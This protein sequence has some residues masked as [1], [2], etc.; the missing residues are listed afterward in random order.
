MYRGTTV[1]VY[2]NYCD[3]TCMAIIV[4]TTSIILVY[5]QE[6]LVSVYN[7][8]HIILQMQTRNQGKTQVKRKHHM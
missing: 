4:I 3:N 1:I 5:C 7:D 8:K 2:G 6:A